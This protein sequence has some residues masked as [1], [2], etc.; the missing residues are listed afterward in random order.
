MSDEWHLHEKCESNEQGS[1]S[2]VGI[3]VGPPYTIAKGSDSNA[4][5]V[6]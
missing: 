4:I 6:R 1:Q 3:M 5:T 2:V